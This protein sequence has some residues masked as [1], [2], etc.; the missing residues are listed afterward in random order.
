MQNLLSK[1]LW[2]TYKKHEWDWIPVLKTL[3]VCVCV[4]MCV[5]VHTHTLTHTLSV[6]SG[7]WLFA[8][9]RTVARQALLTMEFSRQE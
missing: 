4:C 9:P 7:V 5:H 6:L 3:C 1:E 2:K 8:T